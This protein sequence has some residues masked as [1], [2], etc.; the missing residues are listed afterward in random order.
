MGN[1]ARNEPCPCG[2]KKDIAAL[3]AKWSPDKLA[4]LPTE[5][6][7]SRLNDFGISASKDAFLALVEGRTEAWS[8]GN[9]WV[10]G[11]KTKPARDDEDFICLS[12]CELWKRYCPD[13]PSLEM[14]DDWVAEGYVFTDAHQDDKA[15]DIWSR[16]WDVVR[17]RFHRDMTT[18]EAADPVFKCTQ[19]LGNWLQDFVISAQ[20]AA[21]D[22]PAYAKVGVR[23]VREVLDQFTGE[24]AHA[25]DI[26]ARIAELKSRR[27]SHSEHQE[28]RA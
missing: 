3:H 11:V 14:L 1:V 28:S 17:Q 8:I 25:W 4:R 9:Q 10:E 13:K 27:A 19:C 23:V 2:R 26:K 6:I 24:D 22:D 12:A 5:E 15:T 20:N 18:F 16:V 21:L 7:V